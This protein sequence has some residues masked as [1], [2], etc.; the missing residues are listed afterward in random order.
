MK[1]LKD[2]YFYNAR[3][4]A[5]ELKENAVT[6]HRAVKHIIAAVV[7]SGIGFDVPIAIDHGG[8][9][10]GIFHLLLSVIVYIVSGVISFYGVWLTYQANSKGDGRDY[11]MRL[12]TLSLPVGIQLLVLFV[13]IGLVISVLSITIFSLMGKSGAFLT[14]VIFYISVFAFLV[15]YF[16]RLRNYIAIAA[17]LNE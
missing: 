8:P 11:F 7:I 6:E 1:A 9:S 4:L 12:A 17:G 13:G 14:T 3:A 5:L 15:M 10:S 16:F 2:I